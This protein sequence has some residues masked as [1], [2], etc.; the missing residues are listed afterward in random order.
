MRRLGALL[1]LVVI[2][3]AT[4]A[5]VASAAPAADQT[6][7]NTAG[8]SISPAMQDR[9]LG[10]QDT[11]TSF[12]VQV[13][14]YT[15]KKQLI[16]VSA[17]DFNALNETGGLTFLGSD[18]AQVTNGHGISS[19]VTLSKKLISVEPKASVNITA[20]INDVTKLAPGGHYGA[21][22][23][24][25]VADADQKGGNKVAIQQVVASL[26]FLETAGQGSKTIELLR[27]PVSLVT[28]HLPKLVNLAFHSTGN[29]QAVPRGTVQILHGNTVISQGIINE[30]S[31]LILPGSTRL[32]TTQLT[33]LKP[34]AWPGT[35]T[36]RVQYRYEGSLGSTTY[37]KRFIYIN[38]IAVI[39]ITASLL[40]IGLTLYQLRYHVRRTAV[41][42][43]K[44]PKVIK[45]KVIV[46]KVP[47]KSK[48]QTAVSK[49]RVPK[50]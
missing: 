29:T 3:A 27:P 36:M 45:R 41:A 4:Q 49:R 30:N 8:I 42:V 5:G 7:L 6:G 19:I 47:A 46:K 10:P 22:L 28:L 39:F 15:T 31:S 43:A 14:N 38:V 11:K 50:K 12:T 34:P 1:T 40:A 16:Q 24:R 25:V 26:I 20:S 13:Y 21:I 35:Y 9:V 17:Q 18:S 48:E 23:A 32:L 33:R 44:S 37:E 2:I